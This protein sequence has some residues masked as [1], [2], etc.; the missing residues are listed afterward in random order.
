MEKV[1]EKLKKLTGCEHIKLLQRGNNAIYA[2][3]YVV[4]AM[5]YTL[6]IPD[7]GGWFKYKDYPAKLGLRFEEYPT[8]DAMITQESF[9]GDKSKAYIVTQPGGYFV[10]HDL[11][12]VRSN[13]TFFILDASG[14]IGNADV[15]M[16]GADIVVGSFSE[17]KPVDL[18]HGGF[19]ATNNKEIWELASTMF[20]QFTIDLEPSMVELLM[21]KLDRLPDRYSLFRRHCNKIKSDLKDFKILYPESNGICVVVEF[22]TEEEMKKIIE[23]CEANGYEYVKCPRYNKVNKDAISIEVKRMI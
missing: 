6:R 7:Q 10:Q 3:F 2:A 23:Y 17:W 12:M 16:S 11:K 8:K 15:Q 13:T 20:E 18:G 9:D 22:E 5:G 4:N 21:R 14:S 19:F 1:I